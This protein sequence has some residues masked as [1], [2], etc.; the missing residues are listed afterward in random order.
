MY[1]L[2]VFRKIS[3]SVP[4]LVKKYSSL[5]IVKQHIVLLN[6]LTLYS[7]QVPTMGS[8]ERKLLTG[9]KCDKTC[10]FLSVRDVVENF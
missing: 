6:E 1:T 5:S 10:V 8:N 9:M 2:L 4:F 7:F 3:Y